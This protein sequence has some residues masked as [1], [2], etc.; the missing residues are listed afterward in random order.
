M[1][2]GILGTGRIG[3]VVAEGIHALGGR[4]IATSSKKIRLKG[5]VNYVPFEELLKESDVLSIHI[6]LSEKSTHLF[7]KKFFKNEA[8]PL[9]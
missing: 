5:K 8:Q 6:P 3:S 1:T 7:S 2:V 9:Q 4:V